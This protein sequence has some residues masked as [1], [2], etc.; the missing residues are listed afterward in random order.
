MRKHVGAG[1]F[2][3][4][5][6]HSQQRRT[7]TAAVTDFVPI[8]PVKTAVT[9]FY[10][11]LMCRSLFISSLSLLRGGVRRQAVVHKTN[12]SINVQSVYWTWALILDQCLVVPETYF[13]TYIKT[14]RGK[15]PAKLQHCGEKHHSFC[16][17]EGTCL[18]WA[19]QWVQNKKTQPT[20]ATMLKLWRKTIPLH[21]LEWP[22]M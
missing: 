19:L 13:L 12:L 9:L 4:E 2:Q 1:S 20:L 21:T 22:V 3:S 15:Q 18:G 5:R 14:S 10:L 8:R 16:S 7:V 6:V 11:M 17:S